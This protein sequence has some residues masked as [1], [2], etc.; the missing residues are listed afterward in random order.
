MIQYLQIQHA[1]D[2]ISL[3]TTEELVK[4]DVLYTEADISEKRSIWCRLGWMMADM[5]IMDDYSLR[6]KTI[7]ELLTLRD[8]LK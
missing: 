5:D 7:E 6:K 3:Q 1:L 2:L 8:A 4:R